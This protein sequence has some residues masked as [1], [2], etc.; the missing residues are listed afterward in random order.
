MLYGSIY[1][2]KTWFLSFIFMFP[3]YISVIFS[4]PWSPVIKLRDVSFGLIYGWA[5]SN[6]PYWI[7]FLWNSV[8]LENV[9]PL[10]DSTSTSS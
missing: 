2:K 5:K 8:K 7:I 3:S 6:F 1:D 10:N 9:F 4:F